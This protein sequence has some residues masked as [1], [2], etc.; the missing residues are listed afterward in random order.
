MGWHMA[1]G[2]AE[3]PCEVCFN[4]QKY[5]LELIKLND[6]I[7]SREGLSMEGQHIHQLVKA[8]HTIENV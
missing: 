8:G 4:H 7:H 2:L 5:I 1:Y 3:A 6:F